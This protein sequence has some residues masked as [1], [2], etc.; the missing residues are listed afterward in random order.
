[1]SAPRVVIVTGW[2]CAESVSRTEQTDTRLAQVERMALEL[3][4]WIDL[5][6]KAVE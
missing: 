6:T 3:Q 2:L 1:M 5:S 4:W